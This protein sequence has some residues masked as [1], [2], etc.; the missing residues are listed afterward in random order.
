MSNRR[1]FVFACGAVALTGM[2]AYA[3][4]AFAHHGWAWAEDNKFELTGVIKSTKLGNPHGLLTVTAKDGD[5]TVEVGQPWR[6]ER[7]GVTD[8]MLVKGVELTIIGNRAKDKKLKVVK[9]N[10]IVIKGKNYDLYPERIS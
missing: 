9:A 4:Q 7:A 10:R 8:A 3:N 6:N 2:A 1:H 5:W